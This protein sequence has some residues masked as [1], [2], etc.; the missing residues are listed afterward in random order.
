MVDR[1]PHSTLSPAERAL[2]EALAAL[3]GGLL[4]EVLDERLRPLQ[5]EI[6]LLREQLQQG[7]GSGRTAGREEP[8]P[9]F[10]IKP[11]YTYQEAAAIWEVSYR[12]VQGWVAGGKV[13][14]I[15]KGGPRIAYDDVLRIWRKGIRRKG[16]RR[17]RRA[18]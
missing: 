6:A 4:N 17:R 11:A 18:G 15:H 1:S 14:T 12:T 9:P 10:T 5:E 7:T 16:A 2:A 3:V 13:S 8:T